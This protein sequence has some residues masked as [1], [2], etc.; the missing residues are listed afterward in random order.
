MA[1]LRIPP[2]HAIISLPTSEKGVRI[3]LRPSE[4]QE[5]D[6]RIIEYT[7]NSGIIFVIPEISVRHTKDTFLLN[8]LNSE[9]SDILCRDEVKGVTS[10]RLKD[11]VL[12]DVYIFTF[13]LD[14]LNRKLVHNSATLR[15]SDISL[16]TAQWGMLNDMEKFV[17]N[18]TDCNP[19]WTGFTGQDFSAHGHVWRKAYC[20]EVFEL[21]VTPET[22]IVKGPSEF[23][24]RIQVGKINRLSDRSDKEPTS[25]L[26]NTYPLVNFKYPFSID[27]KTSFFI[28]HSAI[29][30]FIEGKEVVCE[31]MVCTN[32][33][34]RIEP[35]S[36]IMKFMWFH[37]EIHC[38]HSIGGSTIYAAQDFV[39]QR[40]EPEYEEDMDEEVEHELDP[41]ATK[42]AKTGDD[43]VDSV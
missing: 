19:F 4:P 22:I 27:F 18:R 25:L 28:P 5:G 3:E 16:D 29:H 15:F 14:Y 12:Q 8:Q 36:S 35:V 40:D 24:L 13:I 33:Y 38:K 31:G 11:P 42:R 23:H 9:T 26:E 32:G 41:T 30:C 7:M 2:V 20:K 43:S 10:I 37:F 17:F 21:D 34:L 39:L 6:E 1:S